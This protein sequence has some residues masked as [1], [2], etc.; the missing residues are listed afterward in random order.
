M[1]DEH[2]LINGFRHATQLLYYIHSERNVR[3]KARKLGLSSAL[4]E[5]I[6][7]YLYR[8]G[9]GLIWS[10]SSSRQKFDERAAVLMEEWES[11]ERSE[12]SGSP[13]FAEYFRKQKLEAMKN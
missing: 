9:G 3:A 12:K 5:H 8:Q 11:L 10:S 6:C 7:Q 4:T 2:A 13:M 1:D